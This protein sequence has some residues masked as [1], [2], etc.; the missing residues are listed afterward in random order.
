L[1][2]RFDKKGGFAD[3]AAIQRKR[4]RTTPEK[5]DEIIDWRPIQKILDKK[6]ERKANA[7][8]NPAY[9]ALGMFKALLLQSWYSLSDRELSE[10]LEDRISFS[11]FCGFSL[12]H[13]VPDNSTICRFRNEIHQ[14]G[15]AK[16][17]LDMINAQIQAGGLEIKAGVIVDASLLESA[18]RPRKQQ[19]V[20]PV[21]EDGDE[22]E[23]QASGGYDVETTYSDDSEAAWTVK[24]KKFCYGYKAHIAVDAEHGFILAGHATPANRPDCKEMMTVVKGC[25]LQA[26]APVF[27]D[28]GYSGQRYR[29]EL[30]D[31]GYFDGIMYKAARNRPLSDPQRQVNRAISRFRG[32]VERAFGT[33]KRDHRMARARYLGA[34]KVGLQLLLDAMAFNLKKAVRMANT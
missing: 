23:S 19:D 22:S 18:R 14:K 34:A 30:E 17:L 20:F 5:I 15:M 33:L 10:N 11:H 25:S 27:A 32:R 16:P 28:K 24:G 29:Q 26:G 8:G 7:V 4:S 9:P 13:Q 2:N 21:D 3:M 12:H 1:A 31:A 6:L